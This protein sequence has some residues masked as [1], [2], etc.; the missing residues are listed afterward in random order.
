LTGVLPPRKGAFASFRAAT[1]WAVLKDLGISAVIVLGGMVY[2]TGPDEVRD[3]VAFCGPRNSGITINGH[4]LGHYWVQ[5]NDDIVDFSVG[6]WRVDTTGST[7][8]ADYYPPG[9]PKLDP[10]QWTVTAVPDFFWAHRSSF[11]GPGTT[12]EL[13]KAWYTG[14]VGDALTKREFEFDKMFADITPTLKECRA[15]ICVRPTSITFWKSA[16]TLLEK[17]IPQ[18]GWVSW[19]R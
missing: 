10:I 8:I 5:V 4:F 18:F 14:F 17:A 12:P 16:C 3:V 2:R 19:R 6:D 9:A 15:A 13:G 7:G 11:S 1:G